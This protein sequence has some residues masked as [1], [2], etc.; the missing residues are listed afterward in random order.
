[1]ALDARQQ[2]ARHRAG[3]ERVTFVAITGSCGKS[4]AKH[5]AAAI[6]A[7]QL[8]GVESPGSANCGTPLVD[9]VLRVRPSHDYCLQEMGAWG[10][11][12]L[13]AG[14][15]LVR[16][17]IGVVLNVRR[18]HLGAFH[19]LD[20]TAAEKAKV[21]A[22]SRRRAPRSSTPTTPA[23]QRCARRPAPASSPSAARPPRTCVRR[24]SPR[25]GQIACRSS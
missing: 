6:L 24:T 13:D 16:P 8:T 17:S 4:T 14:L 23:S 9:N 20:A 21:V 10:P 3:C 1:M 5:L 12:T 18:D 2:A 25:A 11:G 7:E 15:E 22:H 19:D